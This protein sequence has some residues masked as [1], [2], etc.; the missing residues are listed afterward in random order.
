MNDDFNT[1]IV[2]SNMFKTSAHV[3]RFY[4]SGKTEGVS[5]KAFESFKKAFMTYFT[6]ILGLTV[7]EKDTSNEDFENLV[8]TL[9]EARTEAK[10][11]K[12]FTLADT[13]RNI[14][15]KFVVLQDSAT[16]TV[17]K[18]ERKK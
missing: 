1:A 6:D 13:I 5:Q 17:W 14:L 4:A 8:N 10:K 3:N 12:E 18:H 7:E 16:T 15:S 11:K 2:I 9:I